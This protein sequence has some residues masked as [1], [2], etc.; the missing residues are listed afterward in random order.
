LSG[1]AL[2]RTWCRKEKYS[3]GAALIRTNHLARMAGNKGK[4]MGYENTSEKFG[5]PCN[6]PKQARNMSPVCHPMTPALTS[7]GCPLPKGQSHGKQQT[8]ITRT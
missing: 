8:K 4:I 5:S 7:R 2:I 1:A 3:D 6:E